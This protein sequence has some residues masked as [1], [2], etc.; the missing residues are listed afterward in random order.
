MF[1][2]L[3]CIGPKISHTI[4]A[5]VIVTVRAAV[6]HRHPANNFYILYRASVGVEKK[7]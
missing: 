3:S 6:S 2:F 5:A 1:V 7:I 4:L